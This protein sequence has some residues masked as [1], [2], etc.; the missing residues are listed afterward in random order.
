METKEK[1]PKANTILICGI[2]SI[3]LCTFFVFGIAGMVLSSL[4]RKLYLNNPEK[5]SNNSIVNIGYILSIVGI[6]LGAAIWLMI[7]VNGRYMH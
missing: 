4:P 6:V 3:I 7:I 5:Y 1:L 2:L